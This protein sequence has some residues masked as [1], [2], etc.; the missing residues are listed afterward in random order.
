MFDAD[1]S[2]WACHEVWEPEIRGISIPVEY[3]C[4]DWKSCLPKRRALAIK[5]LDSDYPSARKPKSSH[6]IGIGFVDGDLEVIW[7]S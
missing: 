3:S 2:D 4:E 1:D 6:G 7:H 5:M